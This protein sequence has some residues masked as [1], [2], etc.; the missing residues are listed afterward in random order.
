MHPIASHDDPARRI[1]TVTLDDASIIR[2]SLEIEAERETAIRDLMA[3]GA[4]TPASGVTGPFSLLLSLREQRLNFRF[5]G[6]ETTEVITL[7][8][9]PFRGV[10]KD[11]FMLCESYYAALAH[12][13]AHKVQ[14]L[15]MARRATHNE[16]AELLAREIGRKAAIDEATARA[17]FTLVCVLHLR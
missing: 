4:I 7:P 16:G 10:I 15:D 5:K 14:T 1:A 11:Y 6:P 17:L 3:V 9:A 13:G 8:L 12:A 2:R